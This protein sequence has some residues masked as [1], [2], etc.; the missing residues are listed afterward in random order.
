MDVKEDRLLDLLLGDTDWPKAKI[1]SKLAEIAGERREIDQQLA[2]T[3]SKLDVGREPFGAALRLLADLQGFYLRGGGA[4]KRG[5]IKVVFEKLHLDA[6][7]DARGVVGSDSL[8]PGIA[9][10]VETG[11]TCPCQAAGRTA[12]KRRR[13]LPPGGGS[14]LR[15]GY[16]CGATCPCPCGQGFK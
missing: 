5:V 4:V 2:D 6:E 8:A 12:R 7:A 16:R 9:G 14:R 10:L 15:A 13:R 3:T 11:G 1:K